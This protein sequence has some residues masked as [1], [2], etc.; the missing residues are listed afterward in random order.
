MRTEMESRL[1]LKRFSPKLFSTLYAALGIVYILIFVIS[2]FTSFH[3][4]ILGALIIVASL[5]LWRA[6]LWG[7][8]LLMVLMFPSITM[9][10]VSLYA[11]IRTYSFY[12]D[13]SMLLFNLALILHTLV[14]M[15][16]SFILAMK[17]KLFS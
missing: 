12:P 14:I 13:S 15:V 7:F 5:G 8:N 4:L 1:E 6:K 11:S 17:R 10:I 9:N 2:A 16:L 3:P